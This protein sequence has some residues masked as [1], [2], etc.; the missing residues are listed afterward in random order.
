MTVDVM[1]DTVGPGHLRPREGETQ[2]VS[3][4]H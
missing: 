3:S 4:V 1:L 2:W